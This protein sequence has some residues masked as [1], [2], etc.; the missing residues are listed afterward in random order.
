MAWWPGAGPKWEVTTRAFGIRPSGPLERGY[1][2]FHPP[3]WPLGKSHPVD[4]RMAKIP[5]VPIWG[6]GW[7]AMPQG[8]QKEP[9]G[10]M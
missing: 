5:K 10:T 1:G 7:P 2:C 9:R 8:D 4:G 3:G 6:L